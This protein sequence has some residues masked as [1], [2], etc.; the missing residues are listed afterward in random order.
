MNSQ[1]FTGTV[2]HG[3]HWP[4]KHYFSYPVYF[5]RFDLD[6]LPELDRTLPGFGYNR[7]SVVRMDDKDYLWRGNEPLKDKIRLVLEKIG[8]TKTVNRVELISFA[9]FIL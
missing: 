4:Q 3:R 5:Y 9:K 1:V 6:E 2:S 8:Y 7:F